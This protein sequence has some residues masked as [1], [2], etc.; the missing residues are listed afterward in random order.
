MSNL[1]NPLFFQKKEQKKM[2]LAEVSPVS[3]EEMMQVNIK[4]TDGKV[5]PCLVCLE[6][7]VCI[8]VKKQ[9]NF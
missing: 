8:P 4:T 6:D 2:V 9:T 3:K 1:L 7:R 5:I